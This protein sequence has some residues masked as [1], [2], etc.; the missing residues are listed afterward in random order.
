MQ[1]DYIA[2]YHKNATFYHSRPRLKT[3]LRFANGVLTYAFVLFYLALWAYGVFLAD[4]APHN[5]IRLF[6]IP[7]SALFTVSMIRRAVSRPRPYAKDGANIQPLTFRDGREDDSFP[8]R[9]VASAAVIA[10]VFLPY[11]PIV[12]CFLLLGV[13]CLG[14]TRF[15]LGLHYPSDILVGA[16]LGIA[17]GL[18]AFVI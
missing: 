5:Y 17:F 9:H 2:L 14:Y 10:T 8:S 1:Y 12:G 11:L 13:V 16:G 4:F 18:C 6:C 7:V 3:L 15:A